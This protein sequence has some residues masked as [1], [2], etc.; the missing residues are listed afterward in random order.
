MD[1]DQP[2]APT[3]DEFRCEHAHE[4]GEA[5]QLDA[6]CFQRIAQRLLEGSARVIRP[7]VD[8]PMGQARLR[9][10]REAEGVDPVG[11]H[12]RDLAPGIGPGAIVDKGLE[13]GPAARDQDAHSQPRHIVP[14]RPAAAVL[15][16]PPVALLQ[17]P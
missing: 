17:T 14:Y 16:L 5:D 11:E 4:A 12:Q 3:V 6:A 13:I 7:V 8:H 15:W 9:G 1:V 2:I 10:P